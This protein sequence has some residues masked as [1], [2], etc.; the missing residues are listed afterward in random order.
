MKARKGRC[1]TRLA[2][3]A[4]VAVAGLKPASA[5]TGNASSDAYAA[6]AGSVNCVQLKVARAGGVAP[7]SGSRPKRGSP[8][9][10]A[11]RKKR[12]GLLSALVGEPTAAA[13]VTP[14]KPAYST[15]SPMRPRNAGRRNCAVAPTGDRDS[16]VFHAA[17]SVAMVID[18]YRRTSSPRTSSTIDAAPAVWLPAALSGV[19]VDT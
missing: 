2:M 15:S 13:G 10:S 3:V 5:T 16:F 12:P 6:P 7:P 17:G 9:F 19:H 4:G 8:G 18:G 14:A 11:S 1:R